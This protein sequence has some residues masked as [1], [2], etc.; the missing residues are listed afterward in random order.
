MSAV[1]GRAVA[2]AGG[3]VALGFATVLGWAEPGRAAAALDGTVSP[4]SS[5]A[6]VGVVCWFALGV[7]A[8]TLAAAA[9][10]RRRSSRAGRPRLLLLAAAGL[11]VLLVGVARHASAFTVCCASPATAHE[12]Q[13]DV[14]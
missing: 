14:P 13:R 5:L 1:L 3:G 6:A 11:L 12:A 7:T 10:D 4:S 8:T 9:L 2:L